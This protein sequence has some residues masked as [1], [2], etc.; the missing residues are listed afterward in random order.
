MHNLK[1]GVL[2]ILL[3]IAAA[4]ASAAT[5]VVPPDRDLVDRSDLVVVVTVIESYGQQSPLGGIE[6]VTPMVVEEVLKGNAP[7]RLDVF[8]PG[9]EFE[10][11]STLIPGSPRFAPGQKALLLLRETGPNRYSVAELVLGKFSFARDVRGRE[12]LVR[13]ED[14]IVGWDPNGMPHR[15]GHRD[16]ARFLQFVRDV[17]HGIP[18]NGDYTVPAAPV[19]SFSA[20][21]AAATSSSLTPA[22][23]ATGFTAT[24]YTMNVGGSQG[25]R[26]AVF[27]NAVTFFSGASGEPGAPGNGVTAVQA[28][29][30]AWDNDCGSNVN[31]VYGG[32]DSTHT[33]GL[34]GPDG[35]NTVLFERDLSAWGI[36]PFSCSSSGY[37][38]TLGIG[39]VTNASGS[40]TV[41]GETFATTTEADVEMNRG[42]ANCSLLL[43]SGD[44]NSAVAHELGH[45]LGFRHADQDRSSSGACTATAGLECSSSAIMTASI[46][47]GLNA[48]LQQWDIDA[49]RAVYPGGS[50][51]PPP[52]S[53]TAPA[54]TS[55]PTA[56]PS[57]ITAGQSSTLSVAASGTT[58]LTYQ[59]YVGS[60]GTTTNPVSGGTNSSVTVTPSSTTT[61]WVRVSNSCGS[62]NS[63]NV[64]VTVTAAPPPPPPV[65][66]RPHGDYNG[67]GR[68]D[69]AVYRPSTGT[70]Y[71]STGQTAIWGSPN[72]VP[73]PADYDGD[74]KTDF[75]VYRPSEGKWYIILSSNGTTSIVQWGGASGDTPVPADYDGD[76]KADIA[77][78]RPSDGNWYIINSSTGTTRIVQWAS[79]GDTPVPADY[80]GDGKADIAIFRPSD[81]NWYIINSSTGN[82][83][84]VQWASPG[85]KPV[86]AD[87]D[88]DGK[89]DIAIFR[90]SDGNWYIIN[91]STGNTR[92]VQ[93]ASPGDIPQPGDFDGDGKADITIFRPSEG[94]W[95]ITN[96]S[97]G[98][99]TIVALGQ[100]GDIPVSR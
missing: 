3:S 13:D 6:T 18:N 68:T 53:C 47:R 59:W 12:L 76:G 4:A 92:I 61:Y 88:G 1:S 28:G 22:P 81:G 8:E 42:L 55:G 46:T 87:Y 56:S 15:E 24:S 33:S 17:A 99:L 63:A 43:N 94:K 83:R 72:D 11:V 37:S 100:S 48:T 52:P 41:N 91:S 84:I 70:W 27:P 5:F 66:R 19:S 2:A 39:G 20:A 10:G 32:T 50:C 57:S 79:P 73:A 82:S 16:A 78:L 86:P 25:S 26:W 93:W 97:N 71:V 49:V 75:A 34:H 23:T 44:F 7:Q 69:E 98:G 45:T 30:A 35:A 65:N 64:T 36:S 89:A 85:D 60:S 40:N 51:A 14:E 67:D 54:I 29:L 38:G 9:G 80:D 21:P 96:S 58:P 62:V 31:Y 77:I 90:P 74:G 95:Y